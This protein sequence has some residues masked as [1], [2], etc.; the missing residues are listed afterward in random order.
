VAATIPGARN[1]SELDENLKLITSVIPHALW[2]ELH[3]QGF[4]PMAAPI[5][6][7]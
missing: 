5:P 3:D 1:S 2:Q 7:D 4:L 6:V